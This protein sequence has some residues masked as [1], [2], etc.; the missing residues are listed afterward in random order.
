MAT[1]LSFLAIL[2]F[3]L[4]NVVDLVDATPVTD[5]SETPFIHA[6]FTSE[7]NPDV[8]MRFVNNSGICETTPGVNQISG[9]LDVGQNMS[10]VSILSKQRSSWIHL[11]FSGSGSLN[12]ELLQKPLPSHFGLSTALFYGVNFER[13]DHKG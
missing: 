5:L 2:A 10:M 3:F 12:L 6:R 13:V 7:I 8:S 9:Y 11:C 4:I 1:H